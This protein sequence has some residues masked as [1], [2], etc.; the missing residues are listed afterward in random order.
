M[1]WCATRGAK[2]PSFQ[3]DVATGGERKPCFIII[4]SKQHEDT[5]SLENPSPV[6]VSS[7][8]CWISFQNCIVSLCSLGF[9]L[10]LLLESFFTACVAEQFEDLFLSQI[11]WSVCRSE[12]VE[13][14]LW[15]PSAS[16][17]EMKVQASVSLL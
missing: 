12:C 16:S 4:D 14:C 2:R 3:S 9:L 5:L 1:L 10:P 7:R 17:F 13:R 11:R 8:G 15:P 6:A